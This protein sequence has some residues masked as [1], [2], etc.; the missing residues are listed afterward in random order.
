[1]HRAGQ[2]Q[3]R[4]RDEA[5]GATIKH[6]IGL[7]LLK[8]EAVHRNRPFFHHTATHRAIA[9]GPVVVVHVAVVA[10]CEVL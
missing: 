10:A 8:D 3:G 9:G 6:K 4:V 5:T 1:M 2:G 7:C